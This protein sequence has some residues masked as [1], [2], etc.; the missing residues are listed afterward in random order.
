MQALSALRARA[1]FLNQINLICHVQP[2]ARAAG[3]AGTRRFLRPPPF[4]GE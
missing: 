1:S 3:A 4:L 2:S